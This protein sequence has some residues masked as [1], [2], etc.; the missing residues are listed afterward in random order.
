M[1]PVNMLRMAIRTQVCDA[2][3]VFFEDVSEED[4]HALYSISKSQDM[5]HIVAAE[6]EA[7]KILAKD[8]IGEK[9]RKQMILSVL[10]YERIQYEIIEICKTLEEQKIRYM[11]LK[12][13][14]IR[15]YYRE[16]WMRTSAD[17]DVLIPEA[18][19][20][21]AK[22]AIAEHLGYEVG[23]KSKHDVSMFAPSG[24]HLE[25]H[26]GTIEEYRVANANN[27][28]VDIWKYAV[29]REGYGYQY[30]IA[31]EL[32]YF[33]HVAH[34]AKHFEYGGCGIRFFLD[35]WLLEH[36]KDHSAEKRRELLE[37][38]GLLKFAQ[39]SARLANVWFSDGEHTDLTRRM[40][41]H[42]IGNGIYGSKKMN[43][44]WQQINAGG[45]RKRAI[46]MIFPPYSVMVA[47]Y[48]SLADKKLLLPFCHIRRWF[49]I[50]LQGRIKNSINML[51]LN[52]SVKK[53][54]SERVHTMLKELEL[55]S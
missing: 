23:A 11:L 27:V 54:T 3:R 55:I 33:Y 25:L 36:R 51:K 32:F 16:P 9:F 31:D 35:L 43:E 26:F 17:I 40:E 19:H 24:V 44:A 30:V 5:A 22:M 20:E 52:S 38:G 18:E 28:M 48:S 6:L 47:R 37:R 53:E 42:V 46:N 12:G 10:R 13:A 2:E 21:T 49:S 15:E 8:E 7:Q 1:M 39:C 50:V 45:R 29:V 4:L 14:L 34:M 41:R